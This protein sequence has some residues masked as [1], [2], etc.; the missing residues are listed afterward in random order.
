MRKSA[1]VPATVHDAATHWIRGSDEPGS[2]HDVYLD[3]LSVRELTVTLL[4]VNNLNV[5]VVIDSSTKDLGAVKRLERNGHM[6]PNALI[7]L[8]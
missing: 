2:E 8:R 6:R 1:T 3:D 4:G 7:K 5:A